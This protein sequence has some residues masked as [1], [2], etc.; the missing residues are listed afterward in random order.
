LI[1]GSVPDDDPETEEWLHHT[2]KWRDPSHG[3]YL[4]RKS[5]EKLARDAGLRIVHSE[6]QPFKQPDLNWYFETAATTPENREKVLRAV[7][8]ASPRLRAAL[9]L[10]EEN[11]RIVWWWPRLTM[12]AVKG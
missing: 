6:L 10:R 1:D 3:R 12:L 9:G 4:S 7:S 8:E 2:E 11:G 5:W